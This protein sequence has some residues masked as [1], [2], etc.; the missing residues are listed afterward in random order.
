MSIKNWKEDDR[1]REKFY[2]KGKNAVSDSELLAIL[3]GMGSKDQSALELA[4]IMLASN[5]N[6]LD[7]LNRL[8][9]KELTK[10]KGIGPAKAITIAAALELGNRK[11]NKTELV[12]PKIRSSNDAFHLFK[13][14]LIGLNHEEFYVAFL[15]RAMTPIKV[16]KISMGGVSATVVDIKIITKMALEQL[17]SAIIIAHNH[18]SG[19]LLPSKED[20]A[21]TEKIKSALAFFDIA[22]SDHIILAEN[23]YYSYADDGKI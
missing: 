9:I 23:T 16:E 8:S 10:Y 19:N 17:A 22:L 11:Q 12:S 14:F 18:P 4:Q 20:N 15:S 1:P 13:P 2:Q 7:K 6:S 5:D 3:I 21:L